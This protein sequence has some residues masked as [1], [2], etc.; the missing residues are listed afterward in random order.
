MSILQATLWPLPASFLI[1]STCVFYTTACLHPTQAVSEALEFVRDAWVERSKDKALELGAEDALKAAL[2]LQYSIRALSDTPHNK[3]MVSHGVMSVT[4]GGMSTYA[5]CSSAL[6]DWLDGRAD[7]SSY[8]IACAM[9]VP[10]A[11]VCD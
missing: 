10:S 1:V 3:D 5:K 11:V 6:S 9:Y 4:Q 8:S 2:T 7:A